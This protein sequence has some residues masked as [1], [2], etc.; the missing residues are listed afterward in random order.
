MKKLLSIFLIFWLGIITLPNINAQVLEIKN[1]NDRILHQKSE[2]V[3]T[4]DE[5]L[6]ELIDNM[7]ETMD[8]KGGV[9]IAAP[10]VGRRLRIFLVKYSGK[11]KEYINPEITDQSEKKQ[12]SLEGCLSV[13][14]LWGIVERPNYI[15]GYAFDRFDKRFEFEATGDEARVICHEHDHLDGKLFTDQDRA[16]RTFTDK[17][18]VLIESVCVVAFVMAVVYCLYHYVFPLFFG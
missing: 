9:G 2:E 3:G 10:Q 8:A 4:F 6:S 13:P 18:V 7:A 1:S 17:Q 12:M 11:V 15:K 5:D 14:G 16:I